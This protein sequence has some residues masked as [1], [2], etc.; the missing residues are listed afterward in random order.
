MEKEFICGMLIGALTGAL[1][2]ANSC[3][4]RK[5]VKEGQ[6]QIKNKVSEMTK[7]NGKNSDE[8]EDLGE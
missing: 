5:L 3:K 6:E 7:Q 2:V 8:Y 1:V 4:A